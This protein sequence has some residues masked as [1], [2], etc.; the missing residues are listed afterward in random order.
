VTDEAREQGQALGRVSPRPAPWLPWSLCGLSLALTALSLLLLALNLSH[1][2]AHLYDYWLENTLLAV[3]FSI[4]GAIIASRL[5]ANP[6]GWLFCAAALIIAVAHLSAEYAVYALLARPHSLPAGEVLAWLASWA[7][8]PSIG[9]IVLSLLVFPN[10][11]L[12]SHRWRWLAWLSVLVTLAGALWGALSPGEIVYLGSISNP[13][14]IEVLPSGYKPVLTIMPALL[15]VAAVSTLGLRLRRTRG[16]EHQQIKWPAY[17]AVVAASSSVLHDTAISEAIGSRWLEWAGFVG[18]IA[19]LVGFPISIGIAIVRY[20]LYEIDTLINRTLVYAFLTAILAAVYFGAV[21]LLQRLFEALTGEK[22]TLAVVASTLFIATL[23][24]P[25]RRRIQSFID[26]RFYR[27]NYDV[28]KTL[29]AFSAKLRDET[30]L[31]A[32]SDDLVRVVRQ[33]MQ[34]EYASLWLNPDPT[35]KDKERTAIRESGHAE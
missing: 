34:P 32:V 24:Q 14:G 21:V 20:R 9:C 28:S 3:S 10:G 15:L 17:T 29:E 5:S 7:W 11:R 26:R 12:P 25:L 30:D 22:S 33:T 4:I 35:L 19:A 23:F 31:D 27:R 18:V 2:D 13:L 8:I 16:I 6:L 1:P